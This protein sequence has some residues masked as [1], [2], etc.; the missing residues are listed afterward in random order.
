VRAGAGA[1]AERRAKR[2]YRLRGYRILAEN[3]WAA[4]YELDLVVRR[5]HRVHFCEVKSKGTSSRGSAAEMVGREKVRR[6]RLAAEAWLAGRPELS[7][8]GIVF[9]VVAVEDGRLQ[10]LEV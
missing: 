7:G 9:E 4:G 10:R 3:V 1:E 6:L 5:G 2:H 8:L